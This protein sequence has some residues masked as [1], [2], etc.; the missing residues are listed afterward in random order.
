MAE[1]EV[2]T[3]AEGLEEQV[4]ALQKKSKMLMLLLLVALVGAIGSGGYAFVSSSGNAK[5]IAHLKAEAA[6]AALADWVATGRLQYKVDIID[7][8]ENAPKGLMGLLKGE[9]TGKRMIR[10]NE[11]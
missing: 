1:E 3:P 7:G 11:D 6:D 5:E 2:M 10:V 8:L 4:L 9:N